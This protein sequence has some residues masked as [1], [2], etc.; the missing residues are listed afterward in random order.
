MCMHHSLKGKGDPPLK[1]QQRPVRRY[2]L[3]R[4]TEELEGVVE[5]FTEIKNIKQ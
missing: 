3:R 2:P 5:S 4:L 1:L